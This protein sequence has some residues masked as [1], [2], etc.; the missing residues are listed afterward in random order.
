MSRIYGIGTDI[1]NV[2]RMERSLDRFGRRFAQ[3]ILAPA[4]LAAFD[5]SVMPAQFLAKRF[6]VKE[7]TAKAFGTGFR[8]GL[9]LQDIAVDHDPNGRP[10]LVCT[11]QAQRLLAARAVA[12]SHVSIADE[13]E[14]A[15]AFV[16]LTQ[17]GHPDA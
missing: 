14:F 8:D 7:A 6:A 13:R 10:V 1:V 17:S 11:G 2:A 9:R 4:E 5:S 15:V 3:R 12:A 16:I